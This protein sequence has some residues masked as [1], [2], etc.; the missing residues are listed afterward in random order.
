MGGGGRITALVQI[1]IIILA[2]LQASLLGGGGGGRDFNMSYLGVVWTAVSVSSY[3]IGS[4][5]LNSS[6]CEWKNG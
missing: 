2:C 4:G 1:M 6:L 5:R 3:G